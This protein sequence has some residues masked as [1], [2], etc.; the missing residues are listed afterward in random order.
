M[1]LWSGM[2]ENS[3]IARPA[4]PGCTCL[5]IRK[6]SRRVSQIYDQYLEPYG[7]TITQYGLLAHLAT[8][9]GVSIGALAERLIMDPTTLTRNL[10]PLER[11]GFVTLGPD[12]RD[13]RARCL[14]LTATGQDTLAKAK[15]AWLKAQRHIDDAIGPA[16]TPVLNAALD[17]V[18]ERLAP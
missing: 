7:L 15:P 9:D 3:D 2:S 11:T 4:T 16:E 17:H 8:L 14:H 12:P 5:R 6:A 18:L 13:R 10:R 1:Q